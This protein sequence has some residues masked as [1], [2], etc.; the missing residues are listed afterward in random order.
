MVMTESKQSNFESVMLA[1][2]AFGVKPTWTS[3]PY[4]SKPTSDDKKSLAAKKLF[5]DHVVPE[6]IESGVA[7][8]DTVKIGGLSRP[9]LNMSPWFAL[10]DEGDKLSIPEL[11]TDELLTN[12]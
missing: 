7:M 3:G 11:V 12:L 1:S 6:Q 8:D 4:K 5:E 10:L 2:H 9:W